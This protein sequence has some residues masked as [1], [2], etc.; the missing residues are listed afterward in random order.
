MEVRIDKRFLHYLTLHLLLTRLWTFYVIQFLF[1]SNYSIKR[2]CR[3]VGIFRPVYSRHNLLWCSIKYIGMKS[4]LTEVKAISIL[5][6]F[7]NLE[8]ILDHIFLLNYKHR[9]TRHLGFPLSNVSIK[10]LNRNDKSL[11]IPNGP[12]ILPKCLNIVLVS[13]SKMCK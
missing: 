1:L 13:I 12:L 10:S 8:I 11:Q 5:F 6:L 4:K 3:Y 7:F 2:N 9:V